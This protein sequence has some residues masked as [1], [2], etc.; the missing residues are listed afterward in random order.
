MVFLPPGAPPRPFRYGSPR[1]DA[2]LR[3]VR[4]VHL[5][6]LLRPHLHHRHL[7][8]Q[9]HQLL[10]QPHRDHPRCSRPRHLE[11]SCRWVSGFLQTFSVTL[12]EY[13]SIKSCK[14]SILLTMIDLGL[15]TFLI[16]TYITFLELLSKIP[17]KVHQPST[18][19]HPRETQR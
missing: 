12:V 2:A 13:F 8:L 11:R 5:L 3:V 9:R 18:F 10:L 7:R 16:L 4:V 1:L 6:H 14:K 17:Y 15:L 19:I